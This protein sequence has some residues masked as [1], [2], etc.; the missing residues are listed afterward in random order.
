MD[1]SQTFPS[2]KS[3]EDITPIHYTFRGYRFKKTCVKFFRKLY[4][5]NLIFNIVSFPYMKNSYV[6]FL[7][8]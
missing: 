7:V 8:V 6:Y 2:K 5:N 4:R 3:F 1:A